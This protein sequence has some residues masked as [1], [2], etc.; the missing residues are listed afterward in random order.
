[1]KFLCNF[2]D[3]IDHK[4]Y[5]EELQKEIDEIRLHFEAKLDERMKKKDAEIDGL[6]KLINR[7]KSWHND[8]EGRY[9]F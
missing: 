1:M 3:L 8:F 4:D 5:V 6:R 7:H 9:V 2:S